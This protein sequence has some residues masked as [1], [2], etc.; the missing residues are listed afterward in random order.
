MKIG[1]ATAR[2]RVPVQSYFTEL[3]KLGKQKEALQSKIDNTPDGA[4]VFGEEAATL[5][6]KYNA[7]DEK[8]QEYKD[9]MAK[10]Q[11][12][13]ATQFNLKAGENNADAMSEYGKEM[14]KLITVARRI[15]HGDIVPP[16]DEK[17]LMEFDWKLYTAAKNIGNMVKNE[18][19]KEYESLWDDEE[20]KSYEDPDEFAN[21][22]ELQGSENAPEIVSV[23]S[24]IEAAVS[25]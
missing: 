4:S 7:V 19:R 10:I 24:T 15:M 16:T 17:K 9:Y 13:W 20:Q 8:Y 2:Y 5:E 21:S 23:E 22:Q 11:E 12:Q 14:G 1:E 6:L 3:C 25:E 18:K